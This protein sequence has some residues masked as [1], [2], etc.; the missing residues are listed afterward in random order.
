MSIHDAYPRITPFELIL[1]SAGYADD[2]FP[3]VEEEA[4]ERGVEIDDPGSFALLSEVGLVLR[5][6]RGEGEDP[7]LIHQHGA[8]LFHSFH[9]WKAAGSLFLLDTEV[10]R[11]LTGS[12]PEEGQWEPALP[13]AAGYAQ[14]P[15]HLVWARGGE[16]APPESL[17]GFFWSAP[18]DERFS[19]MVVLGLR[20]DL[21]G[22]TVVPLP[23]IPLSAAAPWASM[24][25]REEGEDFSSD[26]PGAELGGLYSLEAG[27]EALKLAMRVFWYMD[28]FPSSLSDGVSPEGG[29]KQPPEGGPGEMA[30]G[31]PDRPQP[32]SLRFRRVTP[33]PG[34]LP[35]RE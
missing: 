17:D 28:S 7:Q 20:R 33:D 24:Q 23:T 34:T 19:L 18:S 8:L 25:V 6:I 1:P 32:S 5:E 10:V 13:S 14:L 12:G 16:G 26:L 31:A 11:H 21:P 27:A 15:Q 4:R 22:L 9:F 30:T 2:R 35:T 29:P 3:A